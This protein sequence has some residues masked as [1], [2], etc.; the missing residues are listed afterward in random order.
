MR[1]VSI[2]AVAA[3]FMAAL[4]VPTLGAQT[5]SAVPSWPVVSGGYSLDTVAYDG[6]SYG[7]STLDN[8]NGGTGWA[9]AWSPDPHSAFQSFAAN[10]S[11]LTYTGLPTDDSAVRA[12]AS[13][14]CGCNSESYRTLDD[15]LDS[16]VVYLQFLSIFQADHGGGTPNLRFYYQGTMTGLV[17]GNGLMA[18]NGNKMTLFDSSGSSVA[19]VSSAPLTQVNLTILRIDHEANETKMWVNPD[20]SAFDYAAPPG[21]DAVANGFSPEA[22][23]ILIIS[24]YGGDS[25]KDKFDEIRFMKLT[26]PATANEPV[27][28]PRIPPGPPADVAATPRVNGADVNWAAPADPGTDSVSLYAV[29]AWPGGPVCQVPAITTQCAVTG[30]DPG[31]EYYFTVVALSSSGWG[32]ASRP[33]NMIVPVA[34][35]PPSL[36]RDVRASVGDSRALVEWTEPLD[37]GTSAVTEYRVVSLPPAGTCLTSATSCMVEGLENG[38]DYRFMVEARNETGWGPASGFS[39]SVTPAEPSLSIDV[40]RR[41]N[42]VILSGVSQG[43]PPGTTVGIWIRLEASSTFSPGLRFAEIAA[44]GTFAWQRRL[45]PTRAITVYAASGALSSETRQLTAKGPRPTQ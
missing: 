44:D 31:T 6:F 32:D 42:S 28:P 27:L 30:L 17:G 15:S 9:D 11:G 13:V 35:R 45:N 39:N 4:V 21:A 16:G 40:V 19:A 8:Q 24:R 36:P 10:Q 5:S 12:T 23:Q 26:A 43:L 3:G 34:P 18:P 41:A 1:R 33:S 22:D 29:R 25:T 14:F 7:T 37:S 2:V 20:L 38:T